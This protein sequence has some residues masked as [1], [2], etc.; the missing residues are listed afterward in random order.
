LLDAVRGRAKPVAA[1]PAI[2]LALPSAAATLG[3][4]GLSP[5]GVGSVCLKPADA[6]GAAG[7]PEQIEQFRG[8]VSADGEPKYDVTVDVHG[9]TWLTRRCSPDDIDGLVADLHAVEATMVGAGLAT[10]LLCTLVPFTDA[11]LSPTGLIYLHSRGTWYPFAPTGPSKRDTIRELGLR[12]ILGEDLKVEPDLA[13][14]SP[15]WGAPGL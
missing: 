2:F 4:V 3:R 5:T 12:D 9:Y 13:R 14:W 15:V 1:D 10:G 11:D 6:R 7:L 8:H